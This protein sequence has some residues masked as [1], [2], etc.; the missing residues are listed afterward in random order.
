MAHGHLQ[1][2]VLFRFPRH[3]GKLVYRCEGRCDPPV[4]HRVVGR[5]AQGEVQRLLHRLREPCCLIGHESHLEQNEPAGTR[6]SHIPVRFRFGRVGAAI[7]AS[8]RT[9]ARG[10]VGVLMLRCSV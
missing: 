8:V 3:T 2:L 10:R 7:C 1:R 4:L 5:P 6:C 9:E